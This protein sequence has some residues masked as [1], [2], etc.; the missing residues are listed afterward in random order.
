MSEAID[1]LFDEIH[2]NLRNDRRKMEKFWD[3]LDELDQED[4]AAR[5]AFLE[6]ASKLGEALSRNSSQLLELAK[7]RIKSVGT[8]E[9]DGP[10]S[11]DEVED[12]FN[13]IGSALG[14]QTRV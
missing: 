11:G 12:V 13:E 6:P 8:D 3:A 5:L 7:V 9:G 4:A 2:N 1:D 10:M 14:D